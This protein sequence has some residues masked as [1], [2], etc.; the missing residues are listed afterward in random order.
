MDTRRGLI[1]ADTNVGVDHYVSLLNEVKLQVLFPPEL[2]NNSAPVSIIIIE[3][4][5]QNAIAIASNLKRQVDFKDVPL[6]VL[7]HNPDP[8]HRPPLTPPVPHLISTPLP[9]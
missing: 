4:P 5:A 3:R 9:P 2:A 8:D 1:F 6:L 7:V